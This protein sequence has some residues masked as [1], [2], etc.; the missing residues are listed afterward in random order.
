M[1]LSSRL[2]LRLPNKGKGNQTGTYT[3]RNDFQPIG[4]RLCPIKDYQRNRGERK[5]NKTVF[6]CITMVCLCG[7]SFGLKV[8]SG[9]FCAAFHRILMGHLGFPRSFPWAVWFRAFLMV[10]T[11]LC[12]RYF[13]WPPST[14]IFSPCLVFRISILGPVP[15][16]SVLHLF[17]AHAKWGDGMLG[18][19]L[20]AS[21]LSKQ[22]DGQAAR[23]GGG[24]GTQSKERGQEERKGRG[25]EE[26]LGSKI[27]HYGVC[28]GLHGFFRV[29]TV[30]AMGR[31]A[32][33]FLLF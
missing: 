10:D 12:V 19:N 11:V 20:G 31:V 15:L 27:N 5:R 16:H 24:A 7:S 33:C 13:P 21:A 1:F 4:H 30:F 25:G 6:Y 23:K 22:W 28:R 2:L 3:S 18:W 14:P 17:G 9:V 8:L 26:I 29:S 32:A